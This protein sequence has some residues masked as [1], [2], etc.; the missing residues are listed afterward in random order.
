M[1]ENQHIEYKQS[2]HDDY[3]KWVCGFANASGGTLFIGKKD[4]GELLDLE[5]HKRLMEAIPTKIRDLMGILCEIVLHEEKKSNF[6]EIKVPSYSIAVSLRGRY[7]MRSGATNLELTGIELNEFLIKKAGKSW[8]DVV[9]E[10]ATI[11]DIDE[12]SVAKFIEE[13][14]KKGRMPDTSGLNSFQILEKLHLT[15]GNKLKRAALILFAKDPARFFPNIQVK[16]GRFGSDGSDLKFQEVIEGNLVHILSEVP[17]QLNYKFLT[18]PIKFEGLQREEKN[19]YPTQAIR[20]MLL[21]ALVHRT[22][23]GAPIQMR[24]FDKQLSIW[25]EGT[26]PNGLSIADL[27][28]DHNSR[29]RNPIIANACFLSGYID[30]WGRGTIKIINACA[31]Y[32]LPEP[33]IQEKNGGI[34]VTI[35]ASNEV[36][37]EVGNEAREKFIVPQAM[38][39]NIRRML[40]E[41]QYKPTE[42]SIRKF[43]NE[44]IQLTDQ[45]YKIISFCQEPKKRKEILED[46]LELSNQTKNYNTNIEPLIT[47]ELIQFTIKDRP[48]SQYQ[49]YI[50]TPKG[51]VIKYLY[52]QINEGN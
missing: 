39:E 13:S 22:Y 4:N 38:L 47:K 50:I 44:A 3:L 23:M 36:G 2:W 31:D 10:N 43:S 12:L 37:N 14:Q 6:I 11:E 5:N 17:V 34:E 28:I 9:E 41:S 33:T 15:I 51:K 29:P 45:E 7:Y 19:M 42:K 32:G 52:E 27:K 49:R 40:E 26:L 30:A 24:V 16:I 48:N 8:D 35:F 46:C 25:N 1:S 20:E 18:R 21:N